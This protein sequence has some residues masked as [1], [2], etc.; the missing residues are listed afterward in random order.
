MNNFNG[1]DR[2]FDEVL[3]K[4][5][6]C[7]NQLRLAFQNKF[8][9][10]LSQ[11]KMSSKDNVTGGQKFGLFSDVGQNSLLKKTQKNIFHIF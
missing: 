8:I 5:H 4:M 9:D 10:W 7:S 2:D 3:T 11:L 6:V 1:Q